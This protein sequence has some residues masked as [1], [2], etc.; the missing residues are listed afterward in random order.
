MNGFKTDRSQFV[1]SSGLTVRPEPELNLNQPE[2]NAAT[3][4]LT[5]ELTAEE[6]IQALPYGRWLTSLSAAEIGRM[7]GLSTRHVRRARAELLTKG[8]F[9][10]IARPTEIGRLVLELPRAAAHVTFQPQPQR[11]FV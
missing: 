5:L 9:L 11:R 6:V 10:E 8:V 7:A 3:R 1:H 2:G 4:A